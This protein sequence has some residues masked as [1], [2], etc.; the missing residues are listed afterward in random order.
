MIREMRE[1]TINEGDFKYIRD[2]L[3]SEEDFK[4]LYSLIAL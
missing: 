4:I 3:F 1:K 2:G